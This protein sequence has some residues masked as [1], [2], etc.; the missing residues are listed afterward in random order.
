M[1]ILELF[2]ALENAAR[3]A[4]TCKLG[5]DTAEKETRQDPDKIENMPRQGP[6]EVRA[7]N[8]PQTLPLRPTKSN[9]H[10]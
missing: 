1:F 10:L 4:Y 9:E 5:F 6:S 3:F 7:T 2:V 8:Q